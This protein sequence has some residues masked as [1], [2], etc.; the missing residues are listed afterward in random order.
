MHSKQLLPA[1][2]QDTSYVIAAK[3]GT[4]KILMARRVPGCA[5]VKVS[6]LMESFWSISRRDHRQH[7]LGGTGRETSRS[8][9]W[10][11]HSPINDAATSSPASAPLVL[12]CFD[13]DCSETDEDFAAELE[14]DFM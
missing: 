10:E 8:M 9:A 3:D 11:A 2:Q 1:V 5:V 7:L 6:W 13:N 14:K 4:D 12:N